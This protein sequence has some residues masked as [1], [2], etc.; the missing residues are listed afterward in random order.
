MNAAGRRAWVTSL[1]PFESAGYAT[2][3]RG[4]FIRQNVYNNIL[5]QNHAAWEVDIRPAGLILLMKLCIQ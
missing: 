5:S 2:A 4:Q 3:A 1:F